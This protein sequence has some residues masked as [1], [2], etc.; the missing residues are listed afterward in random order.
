MNSHPNSL[1]TLPTRARFG[2]VSLFG[3]TLLVCLLASATNVKAQQPTWKPTGSLGTARNGHTGTLLANGNVLVAGGQLGNPDHHV[4]ALNSAEL[5][6]PDTGTWSH[7]GNLNAARTDHT[8]TLLQ[9]GKVLVAGGSTEGYNRGSLSSAELYDPA[10]GTWSITGNLISS[11]DA[12]PATLL[13]NGKVLIVGRSAELYDPA[14]GTW[15]IAGN[16]NRAGGGTATLLPNGKVLVVGF[17]SA[18]LY[19]PATGTWSITGN[20]KAAGGGHTA[21]LLS[22]GKVLVAGAGGASDSAELYDPATGTWSI[23][24]NLNIG[25]ESHTATLLPSGKVMVAAG[26]GDNYHTI[27]PAELYDPTTGMW[28]YT[29]SL[30]RGRASH[31]MMLLPDGKVLVAGGLDTYDYEN[32]SSAEIFDTSQIKTPQITGASISGKKLFVEGKDFDGGAKIIL[33]DENQKTANDDQN[34]TTLLIG[35]KAGKRIGLGDTVR[36]K[37]RNSDGSESAEFSYTRPP[38]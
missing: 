9:N 8:A 11:D 37:V 38:Q 4:G 7:A 3:A 28:S 30:N 19:D 12:G 34:P 5:Y 10:M 33:N 16:L 18:E 22:D 26:Y 20:L 25:R 24:G 13:F 27:L 21:T 17:N 35:K 1:V 29:G 23:T 2:L 31:T 36:L 32:L 15:S 14:T 6:D